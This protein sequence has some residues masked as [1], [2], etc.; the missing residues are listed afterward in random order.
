MVPED[1]ENNGN[2][3]YDEEND[4]VHDEGG[5]VLIIG[6]SDNESLLD[7]DEEVEN[8]SQRST[9]QE[10]LYLLLHFV[11]LN[12]NMLRIKFCMG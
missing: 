1:S 10:V 4:N 8:V 11:L 2:V 9:I 12:L 6:G 3:N 5:D 7:E